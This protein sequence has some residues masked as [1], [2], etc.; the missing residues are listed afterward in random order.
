[1]VQGKYLDAAMYCV[2]ISRGRRATVERDIRDSDAISDSR[3]RPAVVSI[4]PKL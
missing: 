4:H 2:Y 1:M 3:K